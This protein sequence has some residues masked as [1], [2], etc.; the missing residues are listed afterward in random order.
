MRRDTRLEDTIPNQR[1]EDRRR[2]TRAGAVSSRK[3]SPILA[4]GIGFV[5]AAMMLL[6]CALW[7]LYLFR[8]GIATQAGPSPTPVILMASLAPSPVATRPPAPTEPTAA[9]PTISPDIVIGRYVQVTGTEGYGLS[10]RVGP[11]E[12]YTRAD[13]ALDGD[14]FVVVEGPVHAGDSAWWK[15][16]DREESDREWWAAGNFLE[17]IEHP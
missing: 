8:G 15:V 5:T 1:V 17:P 2:G 7:G 16:R 14:V 9:T 4:W 11:G 6:V 13:V 12:N 10:L 3:R